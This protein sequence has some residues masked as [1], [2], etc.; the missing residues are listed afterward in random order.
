MSVKNPQSPDLIVSAAVQL[1]IA[2]HVP[3]EYALGPNFWVPQYFSVVRNL[4]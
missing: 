1:A 2:I 4:K 3:P